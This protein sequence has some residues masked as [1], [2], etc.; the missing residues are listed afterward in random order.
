MNV[1]INQ[2]M[3]TRFL[4]EINAINQTIVAFNQYLNPIYK[5]PVFDPGRMLEEKNC[6]QIVHGNW[7][8]FGFPNSAKRGVYFIFG[9][10]RTSD[11]NGLY[12][13]KAS[14]SSSIG[15]RLNPRLRAYKNS[16]QF[17]MNGYRNEK[18]ILEYM[19]SIDLDSLNLTFL[20]P[21]LE[22]Y[23]ITELKPSLNLINGTG[24]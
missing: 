13:G 7:D 12:I 11:K 24:N 14:F 3:N 10:E 19:A 5:M 21:A 18:Y 8:A 16:D 4:H 17:E 15:K 22:E 20:A 2:H 9:R 6:I 1:E 23:L